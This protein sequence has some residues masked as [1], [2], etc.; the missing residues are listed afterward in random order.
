MKLL[1]SIFMFL[2]VLT[3]STHATANVVAMRCDL[4]SEAQQQSVLR[5]GLVPYPEFEYV[6]YVYSIP[7][8]TIQKFSVTW[9]ENIQNRPSKGG[10]SATSKAGD[11]VL[12]ANLGAWTYVAL[13]TEPEMLSFIA[14][15]SD[16]IVNKGGIDART[17]YAGELGLAPTNPYDVISTSSVRNVVAGQLRE[18]FASQ[19]GASAS[20]LIAAFVRE[21]TVAANGIGVAFD[22]TIRIVIKV[23][24]AD[25][26]SFN[27]AYNPDSGEFT[28]AP[29][30]S[31]DSDG[32]TL[33]ETVADVPAGTTYPFSSG[34]SGDLN[35]AR[36][37]DR[38]A[39]FGWSV[40]FINGNAGGPRIVC[41]QV[42]ISGQQISTECRYYYTR[43]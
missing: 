31:I 21:G 3:A 8:A 9:I 18:W 28:Y 41:A 35:A 13:P 4:C 36:M 14:A 40:V 16:I 24:N 43:G 11:P 15:A 34:P 33:P 42:Q 6:R 38:L 7:L 39:V 10:D 1:A 22:L 27:F 19:T 25:G 20:S 12:Q 5:Y 17:V 2:A 29:G 32:N 37:G 23:V 30:T 26:S